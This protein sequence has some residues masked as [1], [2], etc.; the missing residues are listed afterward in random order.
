[1]T[2]PIDQA[3]RVRRELVSAV[4]RLRVLATSDPAK[5]EELADTLVRLTGARLLSLDLAEAASDAPEAVLLAARLL[6]RNGAAGPYTSPADAARFFTASA[7]LAAV[8]S[9]LGQVEAAARTL[10]GVDG[11]IQQLG[12]FPLRDHLEPVAVIWS[13]VARARSLL[14]TD[15][16]TANACADAAARRLYAAGLGRGAGLPATHRPPAAGGC[17]LGRRAA[18]RVTGAPPSCPLRLSR[19]LRPGSRSAAS[20]RRPGRDR[21]GGRPPR[22]V[23]PAPGTPRRHP[24]RRRRPPRGGEPAGGTRRAG[25][26][27]RRGAD[28]AGPCPRSAGTGRGVRRRTGGGLRTRPGGG[29]PARGAGGTARRAAAPGPRRPG[30]DW[31]PSQRTTRRWQRRPPACR[32]SCSPRC[33]TA[34]PPGW[35]PSSRRNASGQRRRPTLPSALPNVSR[36]NARHRRKR[37][38]PSQRPR[39]G[40]GCGPRKQQAGGRRRRPRPGQLPTNAG[41]SSPKSTSAS[42]PSTRQP[43]TLPQRNLRL[44]VPASTTVPGRPA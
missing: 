44:R 32:R 28:G 8:Q 12:R 43:P 17:P 25:P 15:V 19:T 36:Q 21:T 3:E 38:K 33:S 22:A 9:G 27:T 26:G 30:P 40:N 24:L 16:P 39:S 35:R 31:E 10:A 34:S 5:G 1:M 42:W 20:R 11:W 2:T 13:L 7:L 41:D 18:H 23:R 14:A 29:C 4:K 6:A 37:P